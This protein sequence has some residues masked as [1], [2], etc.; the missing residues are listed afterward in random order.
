VRFIGGAGRDE[1]AP[2]GD[3]GALGP[4]PANEDEI[5]F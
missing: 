4:G 2:A 5:P 3:D 1:G